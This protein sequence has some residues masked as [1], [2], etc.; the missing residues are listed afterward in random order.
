M[1]KLKINVSDRKKGEEKVNKLLGD[2]IDVGFQ[3]S[4]EDVP[5]DIGMLQAS[6]FVMH[7]HLRHFFGYSDPKA[8]W[9]EFG[10]E[11]HMPPHKPLWEWVMR[12]KHYFGISGSGKKVEAETH[13]IA[14][15]IQW[16]IFHNGGEPRPFMRPA[17]EVM[18][19]YAEQQGAT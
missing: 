4:Q 2:I 14:R 16:K 19:N 5:V 3:Q 18:V 15:A 12:N 8:P 1:N 6:G 17:F 13:R 10:T 7:L 11:P 9:L